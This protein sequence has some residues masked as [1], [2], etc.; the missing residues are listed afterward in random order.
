MGRRIDNVYVPI[1]EHSAVYDQMY[2]EYRR[3]HDY[4]G[5]GENPLMRSLRSR[6]RAAIGQE[7]LV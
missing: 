4:F 7:M 3:L 6:R 5:R 1:P 2:A